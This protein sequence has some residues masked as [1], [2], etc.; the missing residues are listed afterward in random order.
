MKE[1]KSKTHL[2]EIKWEKLRAKSG[3]TF[4]NHKDKV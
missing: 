4:H 1:K 3:V 2:A